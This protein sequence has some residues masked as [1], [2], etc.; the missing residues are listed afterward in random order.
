MVFD[1]NDTVHVL[2]RQYLDLGVSYLREQVPVTRIPDLHQLSLHPND[3][4]ILHLAE[5]YEL[6]E[7]LQLL[8]H[9]N[10]LLVLLTR[11]RDGL[12]AVERVRASVLARAVTLLLQRLQV[13][14]CLRRA[15]FGR[16]QINYGL[17]DKADL[18]GVLCVDLDD[19]VRVEL[20]F[21]LR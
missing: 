1:V 19:L 16:T 11:V 14:S 20:D 10:L 18:A 15:D 13:K 4:L 3:G 17:T 12:N 8:V 6:L 7:F 5:L 9:R 21:F 2:V